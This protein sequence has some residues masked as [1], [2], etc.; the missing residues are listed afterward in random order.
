ME[1]RPSGSA[2]LGHPFIEQWLYL[3]QVEHVPGQARIG[4]DE[5]PYQAALAAADIEHR[6]I[7]GPV[8]R[9]DQL[10]DDRLQHAFHHARVSP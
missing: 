7:S 5:L 2:E 9:V 1:P 10:R 6:T 4:G 8:E 3:R